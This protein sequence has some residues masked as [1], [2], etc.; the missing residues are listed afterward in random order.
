MTDTKNDNQ[1]APGITRRDFV[2][3]FLSSTSTALLSMASPSALPE[4]AQMID[5]MTGPGRLDRASGISDYANSTATHVVVN[6]PRRIRN[7]ARDGG[8]RAARRGKFDVVVVGA[9]IRT[10][11]VLHDQP[12]QPEGHGAR[13]RPAPDFRR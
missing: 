2:G 1:D 9:E 13:A 7:H 10:L 3:I 4:A 11:R 5:P 8:L 12:L 6:D